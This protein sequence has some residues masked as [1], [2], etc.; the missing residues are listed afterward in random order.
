MLGEMNKMFDGWT[1]YCDKVR[2]RYNEYGE[3][4]TNY[5]DVSPCCGAE[6]SDYPPEEDE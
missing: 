3:G 2:E 4:L 5:V 6:F 1:A